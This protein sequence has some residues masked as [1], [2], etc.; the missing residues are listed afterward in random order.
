MYMKVDGEGRDLGAVLG[1]LLDTGGGWGP[2]ELAAGLT[3]LGGKPVFGDLHLEWGEV[4]DLAPL[5]VA[6]G[7]I[8]ERLTAPGALVRRSVDHALIHSGFR[9]QAQ[10]VPGVARLTTGRA[11]AGAAQTPGV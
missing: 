4:E 6:D 3:P 1:R 7:L 2:V 10:G 5:L 8:G 9:D 11:T